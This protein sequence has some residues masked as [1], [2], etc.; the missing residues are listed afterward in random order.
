MKLTDEQLRGILISNIQTKIPELEMKLQEL[1]HMKLAKD[2]SKRQRNKFN[3]FAGEQGAKHL[4]TGDL[5]QMSTQRLSD[6]SIALDAAVN[7]QWFSKEG[8]K[9]IFA[10]QKA[11]FARRGFSNISEDELK[12]FSDLMNSDEIQ[13]MIENKLLDSA[14]IAKNVFG[15]QHAQKNFVADVRQVRRIL[16]QRVY[17]IDQRRLLNSFNAVREMKDKTSATY[18]EVSR[19]YRAMSHEKSF[20]KMTKKQMVTFMKKFLGVK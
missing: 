13:K 3:A 17:D 14:Q 12:T 6:Y 16:R 8:R 20:K 15:A 5:S 19:A 10:K 4:V 1:N 11:A 18:N 9:E 7:S 2:F